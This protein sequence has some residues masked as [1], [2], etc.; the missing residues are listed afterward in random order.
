MDDISYLKPLSLLSK[1]FAVSLV[2]S[3]V[4][5]K[6]TLLTKIYAMCMIVVILSV[7]LTGAAQ[8]VLG[9]YA[10]INYFAVCMDV[11]SDTFLLFTDVTCLVRCSI[12]QPGPIATFIK[13]LCLKSDLGNLKMANKRIF[14]FEFWLIL[15]LSILHN[16]FRVAVTTAGQNPS[17]IP[18]FQRGIT[19]YIIISM[20]LQLYNFL[21][22]IRRRFIIINQTL[23]RHINGL[24]RGELIAINPSTVTVTCLNEYSLC[25]DMIDLF[26]V[27]FGNQIFWTTGFIL[28]NTVQGVQIGI[29]C[30]TVRHMQ[31]GISG[32]EV[33]L[34]MTVLIVS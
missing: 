14:L 9:F 34:E 19:H 6:T 17:I 33:V 13:M 7:S 29:L 24:R 27:L 15:T 26:N 25:C 18:L 12:K 1:C 20:L 16:I 2:D 32:W 21:L 23:R 11:L 10:T 30:S 4:K 31:C 8:K 22:L 28:I 5:T 3:F